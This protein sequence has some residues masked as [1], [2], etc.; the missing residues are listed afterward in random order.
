M[1]GGHAA[2]TIQIKINLLFLGSN[3]YDVNKFIYSH[4][5]VNNSFEK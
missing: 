3:F 1:A 4:K 5:I 2:F